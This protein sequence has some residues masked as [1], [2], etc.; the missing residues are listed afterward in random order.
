MKIDS[1]LLESLGPWEIL[2]IGT[3]YVKVS[4]CVQTFNRAQKII[5]IF[6]ITESQN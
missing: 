3:H 1:K 6:I 2:A 4:L 5:L